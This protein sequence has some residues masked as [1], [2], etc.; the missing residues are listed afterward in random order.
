MSEITS[1]TDQ[2]W[3]YVMF[4]NNLMK[5]IGLDR[6]QMSLAKNKKS[7]WFIFV[8]LNNMTSKSKYGKLY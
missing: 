2:L 4:V 6:L 8:Y 3:Y 5:G 1:T 7:V